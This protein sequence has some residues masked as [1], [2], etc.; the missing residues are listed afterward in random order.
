MKHTG[1]AKSGTAMGHPVKSVYLFLF[2]LATVSILLYGCGK[3]TSDENQIVLTTGF[4]EGE[5]FYV[6]EK[7]CYIPEAK[8]YISNLENGYGRV[9]G[10]DIMTHTVSGISVTD[11]LSSMA[12][13]RLAEIKALTL[14][15]ADRNIALS[16]KDIEKCHT[17]SDRY[18]K[19][20]SD[21]DIKALEITPELLQSMYEDYT[22]SFRVYEDITKDVNPEISDDEARIITIQRIYI[23]NI[24]PE[25][26]SK[27]MNAVYTKISEGESFDSLIDEYNEASESKYSFGKDTGDFSENFIEACFDLSNGEISSPLVEDG[28][29]SIIK[30][31]ST[32]DQERT[33][34]H[35]ARM[36]EKRKSDAFDSVYSSFAKSL[37]TNFNTDLWDSS[38]MADHRFDSTENF[39]DIYDEVFSFPGLSRQ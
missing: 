32:Y 10:E 9:Y 27:K 11:K 12:L 15:A 25:D 14:L 29:V 6:G 3:D 34:A 24:D 38:E 5:L 39:F 19:S 30:C 35:K 2:A 22:L 31:L 23:K 17:A 36:V 13:S 7:K 33:D 20:L 26:T 18:F 16:D 8:V 1:T 28:G 4:E 21:E 37:N